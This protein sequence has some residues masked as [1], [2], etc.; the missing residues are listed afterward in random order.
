MFFAVRHI[1]D[2]GTIPDSQ[3]QQHQCIWA[4][5][6][7]EHSAI[8][9]TSRRQIWRW[10]REIT[11]SVNSRTRSGGA[12]H[13]HS[14]PAVSPSAT[15]Q[16][17]TPALCGQGHLHTRTSW[18]RPYTTAAES[19]R[20]A[21]NQRTWTVYIYWPV[22]PLFTSGGLLP[23]AWNAHDKRQTPDTNC[24]ITNQLLA[25]WRRGRASCAQ[26][27]SSTRLQ[28]A[29]AD[30]SSGKAAWH[31]CHPPSKWDWR[32]PSLCLDLERTGSVGEPLTCD[33]LRTGTGRAKTVMRRWGYLDDAQ[34]VDCD[35][36][37]PH[38]MAHLLSCRLLDEACTADDLA[39][40][41][42]RAKACAHKWVKG[43]W[44]TQLCYLVIL[45]FFFFF[46]R[47]SLRSRDQ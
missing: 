16:P 34:S 6:L 1:H 28:A 42:E 15:Q 8:K 38:T 39:T 3:T 20:A 25:D 10:T 43:V 33:R 13:R 11:S 26:S 29:A 14:D 17:N 19:S 35:S 18:T 30:C 7:T 9:R 47:M 31:T 4:S 22:S 37:E 5:T 41:T 23:A 27:H 40:V 12:R 2:P 46:L 21:S 44:R 45:I 36:G 24:S 32:W